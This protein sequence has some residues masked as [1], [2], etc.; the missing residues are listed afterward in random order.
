MSLSIVSATHDRNSNLAMA[1][2]TWLAWPG[3]DEVVVFDLPH[4]ERAYD[5]GAPYLSSPKFRHIESMEP[6]EFRLAQGRNTV[7]RASTGDFILFIDADVM[8]LP[9]MPSELT[10]EDGRYI[11]HVP[12][13]DWGRLQGC[14]LVRRSDVLAVNGYDERCYGWG[15]EDDDFYLRIERVLGLQGTH[16]PPFLKH[17]DHKDRQPSGWDH[18]HTITHADPWGHKNIQR[19]FKCRVYSGETQM[20]MEI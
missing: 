20:E 19:R 2:P 13:D 5:V 11:H 16:F 1:L 12:V 9:G 15:Y 18:N 14:V 6:I 10:P 3:C 8:L 4:M 17:L 7:F